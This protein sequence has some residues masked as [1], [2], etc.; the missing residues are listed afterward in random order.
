MA[1][2]RNRIPFA[3]FFENLAR[4]IE[5]VVHEHETLLIESTGGELVQLKP[6]TSAKP[7]RRA[8]TEADH[9]AFL[10]SLGGWPE[11]DVDAFFKDNEESRRM[12]IR[13]AVDL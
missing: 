6:V 9:E 11:V 3:E 5:R 12:S 1:E 13:P 7:R 4:F 2:I 8:R 10:A